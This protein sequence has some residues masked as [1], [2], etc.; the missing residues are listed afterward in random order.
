MPPQLD[1]LAEEFRAVSEQATA[2]VHRV[3]PS[4]L[5]ERPAKGGWSIAECFEH[6]NLTTRAFLPLWH[7]AIAKAP[8]GNE[9][10]KTDMMGKFLRWMLDPP[11]KFRMPTTPRF[12]P[13]PPPSAEQVLPAFLACQD[14]LLA[15]LG[16]AHGKALD[17]VKVTSPF[18]EKMQYSVWSSFRVN[19][20]HERRHL[21]QAER[22]IPA[23]YLN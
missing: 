16:N 22:V 17:Q 21:W 13:M 4:R 7:D 12:V 23:R 1:A 8:P 19:A 3:G 11:V 18:Q 6:L 14:Q 9:P 5:A 2:L 20:A 15:V 10:F